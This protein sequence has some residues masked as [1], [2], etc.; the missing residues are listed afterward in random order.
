MAKNKVK[1]ELEFDDKGSLKETGRKAKQT[2][3]DLEKG[4]KGAHSMDRRLKGAAQASSNSS[5][6][7]SKMSQGISGGLVPAYATLAAS[8]FAIDAAFRALKRASDLRVQAEGMTAYANQTGVA[9]KSVARD[10]QAATGYQLD[11]KEAAESTSIAIAAGFSADQVTQIGKA[12]KQAS[13]A[14]GR[15]FADSYQRLLKGITK[16]EPELL[17]ELGIILRLEKA[18]TTYGAAIGKSAKDLTAYERQQAVFNEVLTQTAKKYAAVGDDIPVNQFGQLGAK[19]TD[20]SDA[21]LKGIAPIAEFFAGT[22]VNNTNAAIAALGVFAASILKQVV[23]SFTQLK[24]EALEA[25]G[26]AKL[27]KSEVGRSFGTAGAHF[28]GAYNTLNQTPEMGA[29]DA[30]MLAKGDLKGVKSAGLKSLRTSGTITGPQRAGLT[31]A[32]KNAEAQYRKHGKIVSGIFKGVDIKIVRDFSTSMTVMQ[33]KGAITF[34]ALG[35]SFKGMG[36]GMIATTKAITFATKTMYSGMVGGARIAGAAMTKALGIIGIIGMIVM[37]MGTIKDMANQL[38]KIMIKIGNMAKSIGGFITKIGKWLGIKGGVGDMI[39]GWGDSKIAQGE[40]M[41]PKYEKK[42]A[43]ATAGRKAGDLTTSVTE[44]TAEIQSIQAGWKGLG[45]EFDNTT[46]K[47]NLLAG[48]S[49]LGKLSNL[50]AMQRDMSGAY[51]GQ[52]G[53]S[54][55]AMIAHYRE[56]GKLDSRYL[57][58]ADSIEMAVGSRSTEMQ[59]TYMN[60]ARED[61]VE[62]TNEYGNHTQ[63]IKDMESAAEGRSKRLAELMNKQTQY[64]DNTK[65]MIAM[66][67]SLDAMIGDKTTQENLQNFKDMMGIAADETISLAEAQERLNAALDKQK[68]L[69]ADAV[70]AELAAG[71]GKVTQAGYASSPSL[72]REQAA[73][74]QAVLESKAKLARAEATYNDKMQQ[75]AVLQQSAT[76][77]DLTNLQNLA[78]GYTNVVELQRKST[79]Q[80]VL[81]NDQMGE[82]KMA[83]ADAFVNGMQKGLEGL[84]TGTMKAKDAFKQMAVGILKSMA[85]MIAKQMILNMLMGT[86]IGNM[87]G[88]KPEARHGGIM[89]PPGYRSFET[90][91]IATGSNSGY[92]ATLHG[93]EAV[94]PLGNDR[95]IP[96]KLKGG[97]GS[98]NNTTV[99]VNMEGG[100]STESTEEQGRALGNAIQV[101]VTETIVN[102]QLPGGLLN[103]LG[104]G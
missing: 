10:L 98:T 34:K 91:G 103:P 74:D 48:N 21:A 4:A 8:L 70:S 77:E 71:A 73:K 43:R 57:D 52:L 26:A 97:S 41:K 78:Q 35:M 2:A 83:A 69:V 95:S 64:S 90:G 68:G 81:M 31:R 84:I 66:Q 60:K 5:K 75:N 42:R 85:Q 72:M 96:V 44:N 37:F 9:L 6:N 80:T 40:A 29:S 28:K 22:L 76:G 61:I 17:D 38:D 92:T 79:E 25:L 12:A 13:I 19:L 36:A 46:A 23:P 65:E 15:D 33:G 82:L 67:G 54:Q 99:N 50:I 62:L 32:M 11:F 3:K 51:T 47:A 101:A 63:A 1:A 102:E 20:L 86:P 7:F 53:E 104:G 27:A 49:G 94:V 93:T 55:D 58:V 87:M 39:S 89:S 59:T 100:S 56:L 18:T 16:A 14:L 45:D 30:Q 88:L 24:N